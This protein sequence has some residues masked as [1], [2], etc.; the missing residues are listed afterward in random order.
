MSD[1][2]WEKLCQLFGEVIELP[3]AERELFLASACIDDPE[4]RKEI[5]SLLASNAEAGQFLESL[6]LPILPAPSQTDADDPR[7]GRLLGPYRIIRRVAH[8]GMGEVYEAIRDDGVFTMRVAVKLVQFGMP[9]EEILRRFKAERQVLATLEHPNIARLMDGGT[10][11]D[12]IPYLVMEY[13]DGKRI[14]E[15]CDEQ[16]LSIEGRLSLFLTVCSAVQYAHQ[17]LVIHRD[18]KPN[19]ILITPEGKPKL[20]DFGIAKLLT[21]N[22]AGSGPEITKTGFNI[23]TP[24]YASPEQVRG[25]D[26]TTSSDVYSLGMLLYKILTGQKPYEFKSALPHDIARTVLESEATKPS[27][28]NPTIRSTLSAEKIRRI[29]VGDLDNIVLMALRKEQARRYTSVEQF[30]DDIG[31]Y[32]DNLPV[33]ARTNTF[34]YRARKFIRRN[35]IGVIAAML[36]MLSLLGGIGATLYQV[37]VTSLEKARAESINVF[38]KR[39]LSYSNPVLALP[40]KST[41]ETTMAEVLNEATKQVESGQFNDQPDVKAEL[42]EIIGNSYNAQGRYDDA[43]KHYQAYVD[44]QSRLYSS[45]DPRTVEARGVQ[46]GI[47]WAKGEFASAEHIYREVLPVMRAQYHSGQINADVLAPMLNMFAYLRRTQGDSREAELLFRE[48]ISLIPFVSDELKYL[49]HLTRSTLASTLADQGKFKEALQT[50][51][52]AVAEASQNGLNNTPDYGYS[53][54]VL[55]GFL[56]EKG[57]FSAADDTL[58]RAESI[59]RRLLKPS[60]LWLGDNLRNQAISLYQQGKFADAMRKITETLR[61]YDESFGKHYDHYPTALA[62]Q[63]LIMTRTGNVTEGEELVRE[64][65]KIRTETLPKGHFFTALAQ[66]ALGECFMIQKR[67]SEA[68]PLLLESYQSLIRSQ[69]TENPRTLLAKHRLE[70]LFLATNR[71]ELAVKYHSSTSIEK[72]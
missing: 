4:M 60:H 62:V 3:P 15:Y 47:F 52:D 68:E 69:G 67:Y 45:D 30:A 25:E 48:T 11:E 42:E 59:F 55:A 26:V 71:P 31:R 35:R 17:H 19:N 10:T 9:R 53:L 18:L 38:L 61:I 58:H 14:D 21:D 44:L 39:M 5:E 13:V 46:A 64:A 2:R 66:G 6:N 23:F 41:G 20:L 32:L 37:R 8:G 72:D 65:F 70:A 29:F 63:G 49:L 54:T 12:G 51:G 50:A 22:S 40:R 57:N 1:S 34:Q 28:K 27:N 33:H 43:L 36:I 56:A 7:I 24:E 16:K